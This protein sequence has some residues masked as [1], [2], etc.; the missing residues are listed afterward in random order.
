MQLRPANLAT[1]KSLAK[2]LFRALAMLN[3]EPKFSLQQCYEVYARCIG[4]SSWFELANTLQRGPVESRFLEDLPT[5]ARLDELLDIC[6]RLAEQFNGR[7][8]LRQAVDVASL[9]GVGYS[10]TGIARLRETSSPWGEIQ[11]VKEVAPG[12]ERVS[13]AGHGGYRLGH[14]RVERM[15]QLIGL[16]QE[17]YEEDEEA[18]LVEAAFPDAFEPARA[19]RRL[20]LTYPD[21]MPAL[22]GCTA[23][24]YA[25]E[26]ID[27]QL[28]QFQDH[29]ESWFVADTLGQID[30]LHGSPFCYYALRGKDAYAWFTEHDQD[31]ARR[32]R[33]MLSDPLESYA[34]GIE[35]GQLLPSSAREAPAGVEK[36]PSD[37]SALTG[38]TTPRHCMVAFL[39]RRKGLS[40]PSH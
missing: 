7:L 15:R 34:P 11:Q 29:P 8:T 2:R 35:V 24:Q 39:E 13:T 21:H 16:T 22:I 4:Y 23:D 3:L 14:E 28:Q 26:R 36:A 32:G 12:I 6:T 31:A 19:A 27:E 9:A 10:P 1:A 20:H 37:L 40:F 33:Y 30:E 5:E 38:T 25:Q 18:A 17:W